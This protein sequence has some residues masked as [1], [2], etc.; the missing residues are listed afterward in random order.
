MG[1]QEVVVVGMMLFVQGG[2]EVLFQVMIFEQRPELSM[3]GLWEAG[4]GPKWLKRG[5]EVG[6]CFARSP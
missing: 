6:V 2:W 1:D 3:Y 4:W 5:P